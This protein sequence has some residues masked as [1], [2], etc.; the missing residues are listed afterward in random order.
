M[1]WLQHLYR[2]RL[3]T[4]TMLDQLLSCGIVHWLK[5]SIQ[6][7]MRLHDSDSGLNPEDRF[8]KQ[9]VRVSRKY[10]LHLCPCDGKHSLLVRHLT[11]IEL[12][13][14]LE[15][16]PW[17][18]DK[19]VLQLKK[20]TL[21]AQASRELLDYIRE[22]LPLAAGETADERLTK[23]RA[24]FAF[25][26][27]AHKASSNN[28]RALDIYYCLDLFDGY[29]GLDRGSGAGST[30]YDDLGLCDDLDEMVHERLEYET[31]LRAKT[32]ASAALED[33]LKR[34]EMTLVGNP[35]DMAETPPK[36][37]MRQTVTSDSFNHSWIGMY[38]PLLLFSATVWCSTCMYVVVCTHVSVSLSLDLWCRTHRA[39]PAGVPKTRYGTVSSTPSS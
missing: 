21:K 7:M 5:P 37:A 20:S 31:A 23:L 36:K 19:L 28:A 4:V 8:R 18:R 14:D 13:E 26:S 33:E 32:D 34:A 15:V 25:E 35:G 12:S 29:R 11:G 30:F 27:K 9:L 1:S 3:T 16:T 38:L 6:L 24:K 39:I 2:L 10:L 17:A 22:R